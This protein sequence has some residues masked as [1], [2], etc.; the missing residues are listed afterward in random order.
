MKFSMCREYVVAYSVVTR[1]SSARV[2]EMGMALPATIQ[3]SW[4]S[5]RLQ[6]R[7]YVLKSRIRWQN[8]KMIWYS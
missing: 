7:S 3:L 8:L 5:F 2:T 1:I 6:I 4:D